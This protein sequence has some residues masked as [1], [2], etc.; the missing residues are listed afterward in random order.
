MLGAR[1]ISP[2]D[3]GR[4]FP[5]RF[6]PMHPY[7]VFPGSRFD[8]FFFWGRLAGWLIGLGFLA[9]IVLAAIVLVLA[10]TRRQPAQVVSTPSAP[11]RDSGTPSAPAAVPTPGRTCPNCARPVQEDWSHCPYCGAPLAT[12]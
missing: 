3:G 2:W 11:V 6:M 8:G 7:G 10:L 1:A 4:L 12:Q 5:W 9:L